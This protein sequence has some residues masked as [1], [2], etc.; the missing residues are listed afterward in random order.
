VRTVAA[1]Y[2]GA[3][4][5]TPIAVFLGLVGLVSYIAVAMILADHI[6]TLHWAVQAVYFVVAGMAWVLPMRWLMFWAVH[7][8]G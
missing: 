3:M 6:L 1:R 5:R 2:I 8:R 7:K 4:S